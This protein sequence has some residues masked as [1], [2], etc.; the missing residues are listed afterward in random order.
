LYYSKQNML[1]QAYFVAGGFVSLTWILASNAHLH[2]ANP[3]YRNKE[4]N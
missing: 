2:A 4:S 3:A 1:R